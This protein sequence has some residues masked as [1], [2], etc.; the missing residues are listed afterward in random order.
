MPSLTVDKDVNWNKINKNGLENQPK[1]ITEMSRVDNLDDDELFI[2]LVNKLLVALV[3][4]KHKHLKSILPLEYGVISSI[5]DS[6][7]ILDEEERPKISTK[8]QKIINTTTA[9]KAVNYMSN[10]RPETPT[11]KKTSDKIWEDFL[12]Q[13]RF[14][15]AYF[16]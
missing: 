8:T 5:L 4:T 6:S 10:S 15:W 11:E 2:S 14:I 3:S 9:I 16:K 12:G 7:I 13:V 1:A